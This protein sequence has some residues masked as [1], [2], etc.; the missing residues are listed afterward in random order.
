MSQPE[1]IAI[2]AT[3]LLEEISTL[4]RD[5][6]LKVLDLE[7]RIKNIE[8]T[9]RLVVA[10]LRK[11][12]SVK[13]EVVEKQ[14]DVTNLS[15]SNQTVNSTSPVGVVTEKIIWGDGSPVRMA[16]V[17]VVSCNGSFRKKTTTLPSGVWQI[18]NIPFGEYD[19]LL[20]KESIGDR[21][22]INYKKS[23]IFSESPLDLGILKLDN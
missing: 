4:I 22:A 3:L 13:N 21:P 18:K 16:Y 17:E 2:K 15:S 5:T 7:N 10:E 9:N 6:N 20:T 14:N 8:L 11:F 23:F 12:N 19:L 1:E